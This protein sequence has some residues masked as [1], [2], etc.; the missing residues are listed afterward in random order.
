[1]FLDPRFKTCVQ[2]QQFAER[3]RMMAVNAVASKLKINLENNNQPK[4]VQTET[5]QNVEEDELSPWACVDKRLAQAP[6]VNPTSKGHVEIRRYLEEPPLQR[7]DDPL[8]WWKNNHFN[9]PHLS[10]VVKGH[11]C[12]LATSVPCERLFSKGGYI[13]SD[14][15]SRLSPNKIKQIMFINTNIDFL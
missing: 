9:F 8:A 5:P 15:R 3:V 12:C 11:F 2:N 4:P 6:K 13:M 7:Q 14:R 10:E 1:M